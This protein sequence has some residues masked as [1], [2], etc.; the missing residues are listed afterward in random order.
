MSPTTKPQ[1]IENLFFVLLE[2]AG[3]TLI[4][5]RF[6]NLYTLSHII[7]NRAIHQQYTALHKGHSRNK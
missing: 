4:Y 2:N 6:N 7:H 3:N 1:D 5:F